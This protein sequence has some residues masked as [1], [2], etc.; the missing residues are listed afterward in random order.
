MSLTRNYLGMTITLTAN[1]VT[2]LYTALQAALTA[3]EGGVVPPTAREY[4]IQNDASSPAAVLVGDA[5]VHASPQRCSYS[6]VAG[7]SK[8][9]RSASVQDCPLLPVYLLSSGAAILNVEA[10][11]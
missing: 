9:F 1:T 4:T 11:C 6:L 7:Q 3:A 2:N 5:R 10:W 8:T